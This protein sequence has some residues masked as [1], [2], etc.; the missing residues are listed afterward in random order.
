MKNRYIRDEVQDIHQNRIDNKL[1]IRKKKVNEIL[2]NRRKNEFNM[3]DKNKESIFFKYNVYSITKGDYQGLP[4]ISQSINDDIMKNLN[5][6]NIEEIKYGLSLLNLF[7]KDNNNNKTLIDLLTLLLSVLSKK[8]NEK[9][10]IFNVFY[11][12]TNITYKI[13]TNEIARIL[14]DEF[15]EVIKNAFLI[16]DSDIIY[17]IICSLN[18]IMIVIPVNNIVD[19]I[20]SGLFQNYICD[21]FMKNEIIYEIEYNNNKTDILNAI[22][23]K[24]INLFSNILIESSDISISDN[25]LCY[26]QKLL[27]VI[28]N[29]AETYDREKY[30]KCLYCLSFALEKELKLSTIIIQNKFITKT[31]LNKKYFDDN[32]IIKCIN[33]II[34]ICFNS[35][36]EKEK[37]INYNILEFEINNLKSSVQS[38][39]A[40]SLAILSELINNDEKMIDEFFNN[41]NNLLII[42]SIYKNSF[43]NSEIN[44]IAYFFTLLINKC[45][46]NQ[47]NIIRKY[48]VL[49]D[50]I[51][52]AKRCD[53]DEEI[54]IYLQLIQIILEYGKDISRTKEEN[55]NQN[56]E[57]LDFKKY[58]GEE[59]IGKLEIN[60]NNS[61]ISQI[62]DLI[63]NF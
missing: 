41:E 52:H 28:F 4:F 18:N 25:D 32:D 44:E 22:I 59:L 13:N 17:Q 51:D 1:S 26:F 35:D 5:S 16:N 14:S 63:K 42:D 43:I 20:K 34:L 54:I 55:N 24:G 9:E 47:Y 39:K 10:V 45:D 58:G 3:S 11:S 29:F 37:Y 7:I 62:V 36:L 53:K 6:Q 57:A 60:N 19:F 12:F 33:K 48:N 40:D 2:F 46:I 61:E 49:K 15:Y 38:N 8:I 23:D 21:Y 31:L 30:Y 50:T 56:L 27:I